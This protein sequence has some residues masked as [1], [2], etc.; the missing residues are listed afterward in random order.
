MLTWKCDA[1]VCK[2]L[3]VFTNAGVVANARV[4][5]NACVCKHRDWK[6]WKRNAFH[7]R[8]P[9]GELSCLYPPNLLIRLLPRGCFSSGSDSETKQGWDPQLSFWRP[10]RRPS[11]ESQGDSRG[12]N[13]QILG[14]KPPIFPYI[15]PRIPPRFPGRPPRR[16]PKA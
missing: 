14:A 4:F 9:M 8:L 2:R 5:A 11:G 1:R 3:L 12:T 16:P 6:L 7:H 15:S 10:S 13:K